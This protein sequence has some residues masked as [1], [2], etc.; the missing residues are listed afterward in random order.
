MNT[1][2]IIGKNAI[3]SLTTGMYE[4]SKFIFREYIQN[5]ADQIDKAV[6]D[7]L[8]TKADEE[9]HIKIDIDNNYI[10][11]FDNATGIPKDKV[12]SILLNVAKSTK[13]KGVDK[14]FRGIGRLGGL[15]YC[16]SLIFE[17]STKG[18][19]VKSILTWD[20]SLLKEIINNAHN[21]DS[22]VEVIKQVTTLETSLEDK[23]K[24]Y[25]RV[26]LKGVTNKDLL[27]I[28][29]VSRYLSM[30]SPV[31]YINVFYYKS[32]IYEYAEKVQD[33]ID[34]Y[35]IYLNGDLIYKSYSTGIYAE[36]NGKR[37]QVDEVS[38]LVF[39]DR[40]ADDGE[41]LYWGWY[42]LSN[43]VGQMKLINSARGIRLRKANIQ[44]GAPDALGKFFPKEEDRWSLYFF[45]EV[46][47][48]HKGLV[49]NA[50]RDYFSENPICVE[51]EGKLK[52]DL[53]KAYRLCYE[54]SNLRSRN[55]EIT[56]ANMLA[57]TISQK[58]S[59]GFKSKEEREELYLK[60]EKSKDRAEKAKKEIATLKFK[61]QE[62]D[63][64]ILKVFDNIVTSENLTIPKVA[65]DNKKGKTKYVTDKEQY[66]SIPKKDRK[67][68][69][70]IYEIIDN[71]LPKEMADTLI[72]KI[73]EELTK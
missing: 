20:A 35:K 7:G 13:I 46:H 41:L 63:S 33:N 11:V 6:R 44:I 23:D 51:F 71:V 37:Q 64:P 3:E 29:S 8:L 28:H 5:S 43:F 60:F 50:R 31:D 61:Y 72:R 16:T 45:G 22:A 58:E 17:T 32:K 70:R 47:A 36:N 55:K 54:A 21:D 15:G 66:S 25:F 62:A 18:E 34:K 59:D 42:S 52:D 68:I 14:G 12:S 69:G 49:P 19:D 30:V 10:E 53:Y 4:D 1:E 9:I 24:H 38:D 27:D 40:Y 65:L 73:E 26:I 67:L 2:P 39:F 56:S 57:E 48:V